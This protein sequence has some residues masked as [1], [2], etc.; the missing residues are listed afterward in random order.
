MLLILLFSSFSIPRRYRVIR[1]ADSAAHIHEAAAAAVVECTSTPRMIREAGPRGNESTNNYVLFQAAQVVL[2]TTDRRLGEDPGGFLERSC[3]NER[4]GGQRSLGNTQQH[5]FPRRL[6]LSFGLLFRNDIEQ[7]TAIHLFAAKQGRIAGSEYF[8][9]TQHLPHDDFDV[10]VVDLHALQT[11]DVLDFANQVVRQR[12]DALQTQYVVR[13][14]L[15]VGDDFTLFHLFAFEYVQMPPL[16][17]QLFVLVGGLVGD[18]QA[19]L[20]LGLLAEADRTAAFGQNRGILGLAG[21]EQIGNPRQTAGDIASLRRLLR[22]TRDDVAHRHFGSV[23]QADDG[24]RRQRVNRRDIGI[25]ERDFLALGIGQAHDRTQ[26]LAA[27]TTLLRIEHDGAGQTGNV[28]HLG[29]DGDAVDEVGELDHA[30]HFRDHGVRMRIPIR[31]RLTGRHH[32]GIVH[33]D[34]G[35]VRDLIALALAAKLIDHAQFTGAR[36]RDQVTLLMPHGLD[37]VQAYCALRLDLDA[38]GRC[39]S[40]G[41]TAD[42]EGTH[43]ELGSRLADRLRRDHAHRFADVN[44]MTT[45]QI[46]AVAP[47]ANAVTGLASDG[48]THHDLIDAHLFQ[49]FDQL[50]IDQRTGLDQ[51]FAARRN[52]HVFRGHTTQNALAQAFDHVAALDDRGDR[53]AEARAAIDLGHHQVLRHIDQP[54]SEVA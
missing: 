44:A 50:F 21:L 52:D 27:R 24:A 54:S 22:D 53:Q 10:L 48:R 49:E 32:I 29:R 26:V 43:G 36:Y 34:G 7:T 2:E 1:V 35:A 8:D 37:V 30:G 40:G 41:R 20:A 38:I 28:V 4:L 33:R 11:I 6:I 46:A 42:V 39:R 15:A 51:H 5:G 18:D 25:G 9:F 23:F 31:H 17:D 45:T 14:G 47:S 13:I 16:G 19:P 3:R 12:L